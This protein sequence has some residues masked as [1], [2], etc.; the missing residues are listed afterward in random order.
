LVFL[1]ADRDLTL[2]PIHFSD[3][4]LLP[5]HVRASPSRWLE[6]SAGTSVLVKQAE[7]MDEPVWQGSDFAL[8]VPFGAAF[9]GGELGSASTTLCPSRAVPVAAR[10]SGPA[11]TPTCA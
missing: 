7:A 5:V 2:T 11:S 3:V 10:R 8:R 9:A 6:L 1:T 4:G